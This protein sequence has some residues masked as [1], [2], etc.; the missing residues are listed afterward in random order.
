M[1]F[2]DFLEIER[3]IEAGEPIPKVIKPRKTRKSRKKF[4]E[5]DDVE[6]EK[7]PQGIRQFLDD[8]S[9]LQNYLIQVCSD[10]KNFSEEVN[11]RTYS[12]NH[13][14]D[15][16]QSNL[17]VFIYDLRILLE[18]KHKSLDKIKQKVIIEESQ[19]WNASNQTNAEKTQG[20]GG[21]AADEQSRT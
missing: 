8:A 9:S 17:Q 15:T 10:F 2:R 7:L 20:T 18:R 12:T 4:F 14:I 6:F 3:K 13:I 11:L 5:T 21:S 16:Y 19:K 1:N